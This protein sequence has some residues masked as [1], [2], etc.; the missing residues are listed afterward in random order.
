MDG[1][2]KRLFVFERTMQLCCDI[3]P[4]IRAVK[5]S[6]EKQQIIWQ[7][8]SEPV[9]SP[10]YAKP[11]RRVLSMKRTFQAARPYAQAGKR[12]CALNFA[13]SVSP[14]GGVT[15]GTQAQEE[16]LCRI[17]TLYPALASN[18]AK[19]FYS[20]HWEMIR[21]GQMRRENRDDCIYTPGVVVLCEDG[22]DERP[23]PVQEHYT[24][25]VITCAAPDLRQTDDGSAYA[26]GQQELEALLV[27]RW[28]RILALAASKGAEVLIL[29]AFGCGVFANPP[30]LVAKAFEQAAAEIDHCF[31]TIEFAVYAKDAEAPNVQG[32]AGLQGIE[33]CY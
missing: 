21:A 32:F 5:A 27:K 24:V 14:G 29:G 28:R 16:S 33:I 15:R 7:E 6:K 17:S 18:S 11:A 20:K 10:R 26:P 12:V 23:L 31:E 25:D 19:A 30:R 8:D 22:G 3:D 2:E 4:L 13:S 9:W 1:R